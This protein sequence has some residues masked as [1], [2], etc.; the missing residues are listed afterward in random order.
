MSDER[1][2]IG[3]A[4]ERLLE[5]KPIRS[6]GALTVVALAEE[7]GVKR[8]ILTH[9]HTDLKDEFYARVK[10]Q[11]RTPESEVKLKEGIEKLQA[12]LNSVKEECHELRSE[13]AA[14][15]R[16]NNLLALENHQLRQSGTRV[17]ALKAPRQTQS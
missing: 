17:T 6:S 5:G 3:R 2:Q 15:R 11:G 4:M 8:H 1:Q 10:A 7:A 13:V 16:I 14:L 9:R 12:T